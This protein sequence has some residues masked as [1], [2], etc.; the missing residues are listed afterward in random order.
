MTPVKRIEIMLS[1]PLVPHLVDLLDRHR[2]QAYCISSD[3]SGRST[4]AI[5]MGG[6][7]DTIVTLICSLHEADHLL[8]ALND[9]VGTYGGIFTVLDALGANIKDETR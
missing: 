4:K 3:H 8:P 5:G 2:F 6:I 7:R 9:F 1:E